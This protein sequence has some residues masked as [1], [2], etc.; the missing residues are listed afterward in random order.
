MW[1]IG[2]AVLLNAVFGAVV[3]ATIDTDDQRFYH[4]YASAP[5]AFGGL[6]QF[7]VLTAWPIGVW[8]WWRREQ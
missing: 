7:A 8:C 2:L 3:W 4:W 6:L 5:K 1:W